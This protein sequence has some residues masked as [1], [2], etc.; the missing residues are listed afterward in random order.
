MSTNADAWKAGI[1]AIIADNTLNRG[2]FADAIRTVATISSNAEV[3]D[4]IDEIAIGWE[5]IGIINNPT[6]NSL[7]A[8]IINEGA[9]VAQAQF[10]SLQTLVN[11]LPSTLI[12]NA[13]LRK[14]DLRAERDQIDANIVTL[15]D[16][17]DGENR[18]VKEA[19]NLGI[20]HLRQYKEQVRDELKAIGDV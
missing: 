17:K 1:D 2:G 16:L 8:E 3:I 7:R 10:E 6:Y 18:Q 11:A 15:V 5:T 13:D 9:T 4:W 19:I 20:N 14:Q 12:I